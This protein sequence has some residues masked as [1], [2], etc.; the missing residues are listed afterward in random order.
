M[1]S[2]RLVRVGGAVLVG[3][4][5][6]LVYRLVADSRDRGPDGRSATG[7]DADQRAALDDPDIERMRAQV[8][9]LQAQVAVLSG[10]VSAAQPV[11][12]AVEPAESTMSDEERREHDERRHAAYV[13]RIEAGFEQ[14]PVDPKWAAGTSSRVWAVINQME[15][16]RGAALEV[17]CRSET[18]RLE[19][20]DDGS[21]TLHKNLPLFAQ[22]FA[23]TMPR[24]AGR[25]VS[26]ENGQSRMVLFLMG[27]DVATAPARQN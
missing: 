23:D 17:E 16:L 12:S 5:L 9:L 14:E 21:G 4:C 10:Q 19:I 25:P 24:M 20:G 13:D 1:V 18:C 2:S 27:P 11:S 22:Q 8:G 26:D 7:R 15:A 3:G 6:F